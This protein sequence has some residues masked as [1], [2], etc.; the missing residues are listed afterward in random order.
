M[1]RSRWRRDSKLLLPKKKTVDKGSSDDIVAIETDDQDVD[2]ATQARQRKQRYID[3]TLKGL[4]P[5]YLQRKDQ[6]YLVEHPYA[7]WNELSTH[8]FNKDVK[9]QVSTSFLNDEEQ[10]KAQITSLGHE[11][12]N[13]PTEPSQHRV[14][15]VEGN[16][17][18][19]DPNQKGKKKTTR[20]CGYCRTN[21]HTPS[22]CRKKIRD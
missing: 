20:F 19:I 22:Y 14:N 4:R 12:K 6:K 13:L 3:F 10:H 1:Y 7:A 9:Y 11:L 15:A 21:G 16:Q 5:G 8:L 2:R 17:R 18:H